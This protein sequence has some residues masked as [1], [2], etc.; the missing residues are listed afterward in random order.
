M[1]EL[2][3]KVGILA[4]MIKNSQ[5]LVVITGAG[6]STNAGIRD[7]RGPQGIWTLESKGIPIETT[8]ENM[9]EFETAKPT[10][11]HM[12][13]VALC[14]QPP[15]H[16]KYLISQNVDNLH[17]KSGFPRDKLAELHGN[18]F[19]EKCRKCKLE[20]LRDRDVGGMGLKGTGRKCLRCNRELID[21]VLDWEDALPA[22]EFKE[23]NNQCKQADVVL[24]LAT[25][26]R[27]EPVG[28]MPFLSPRG[29]RKVIICNLQDTPK[30]KK[31]D[32]VIHGKVDEVM[33]L[34]MDKLGI[35]IPKFEERKQLIIAHFLRKAKK[36]Q[37]EECLTMDL[38]I[39]TDGIEIR[40]FVDRIEITS[41]IIRNEPLTLT[42]SFNTFFTFV[43]DALL[44]EIHF[45]LKVIQK[46]ESN[47]E[48]EKI[49]ELDYHIKLGIF[50]SRDFRSYQ[51]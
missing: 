21:T 46:W 49:N 27:I 47:D 50:P 33:G 11:T 39:T 25:S 32:L 19:M 5:R 34:L 14:L 31:A 36:S 44:E 48:N 12:A 23:S 8:A 18:L 22:S 17:L 26:L 3:N 38:T 10:I 6:I 40:N 13:L 28:N 2:K 35:P 24:C 15:F 4:E 9:I 42:K 37:N 20:Y 7:F 43:R 41:N 51:L 16:L 29:N 45:K 30:D 1:D